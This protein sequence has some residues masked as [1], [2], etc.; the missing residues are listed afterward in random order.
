MN[1]VR[2]K[3]VLYGLLFLVIL[4]QIVQPA[5][6]NPPVIATRSLQA[7][8]KVPAQIQS[9]LE[10]SCYDCHSN[11]TVWPWYSHI[12]PVSW[13]ITDDVNTGRMHINF[14]DW[15]AQENPREA[16]EHLGLICEVVKK[17]D[18]PPVDYRFMHPNSELTTGDVASLCA[19]SE[20]FISPAT[21]DTDRK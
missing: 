9:V 12:A 11:A 6:T 18:M 13:L 19:W 8:A 5:R 16:A 2:V 7:H 10:R 15:E 21:P 4:I 1:K 20:S 14:Q 3:R 17:K